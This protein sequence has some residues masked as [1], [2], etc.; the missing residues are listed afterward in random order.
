MSCTSERRIAAAASPLGQ[1]TAPK[2]DAATE[3]KST[4]AK[5]PRPLAELC[6]EN[7]GVNTMT[8]E[9]LTHLRVQN[10]TLRQSLC[11]A[12]GEADG[13]KYST[14]HMEKKMDDALLQVTQW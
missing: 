4:R 11:T 12:L 8:G 7:G 3:G 9:E 2:I 6:S 10:A 14:N 5:R 1:S 13:L